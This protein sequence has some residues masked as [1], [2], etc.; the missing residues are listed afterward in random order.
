MFQHTITRY[1]L[2]QNMERVATPDLQAVQPATKVPAAGDCSTKLGRSMAANNPFDC[3]S[4]DYQKRLDDK[5]ARD[6]IMASKVQLR[7]QF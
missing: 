7:V 1:P 2:G 4:D 3:L 5:A 6:A